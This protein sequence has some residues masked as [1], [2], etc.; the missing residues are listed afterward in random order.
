MRADVRD[1]TKPPK[2]GAGA[3]RVLVLAGA[4]EAPATA[5]DIL[6]YERRERGDP[7]VCGPGE[8]Q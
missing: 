1:R 8:L 5:P 2:T 4:V 3:W 6:P 7:A